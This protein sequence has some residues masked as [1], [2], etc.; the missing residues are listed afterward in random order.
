M[1]RESVVA[2]TIVLFKQKTACGVSYG[3]VGSVMWVRGRLER[4][5]T[6]EGGAIAASLDADSEGEEGRFYVWDMVQLCLLHT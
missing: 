1:S 2:G 4:E 5:M 3:L 6:A